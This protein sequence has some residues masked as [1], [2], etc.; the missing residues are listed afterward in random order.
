[1]PEEY[2]QLVSRL[3]ANYCRL[4]N[5]LQHYTPG[6]GVSAVSIRIIAQQTVHSATII[7][8]IF[9]YSSACIQCLVGFLI[10]LN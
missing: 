9:A 4:V 2:H 7:K 1:M 8:T 10:A 3:L 6:Q 5:S